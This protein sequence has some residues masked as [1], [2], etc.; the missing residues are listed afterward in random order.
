MKITFRAIDR[1]HIGLVEETLAE[2]DLAAANPTHFTP[3]ELKNKRFGIDKGLQDM[4]VIYRGDTLPIEA[5]LLDFR[6]NPH[7][8]L[9]TA[10]SVQLAVSQLTPVRKL[11]FA[12]TGTVIDP[13][14]GRVDFELTPEETD[15]ASV[16]EALGNVRLEISAGEYKTFESFS[17]H[18]KDSA[19]NLPV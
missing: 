7:P 15:Q 13:L 11:L 19:F 5:T 18:F 6:G 2:F 4:P 12:V 8:A 3:L 16:D 14:L 1:I 17:V 9:E 10:L